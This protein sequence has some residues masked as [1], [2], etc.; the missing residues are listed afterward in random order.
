MVI[1]CRVLVL[2]FDMACSEA[3]DLSTEQKRAWDPLGYRIKNTKIPHP[4]LVPP[5]KAN[6]EVFLFPLDI[7]TVRAKGY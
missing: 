7:P 3:L 4:T 2:L 1:A 5:K 6:H